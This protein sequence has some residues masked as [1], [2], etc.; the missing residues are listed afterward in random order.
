MYFNLLCT[1]HCAL[2][3][4]IHCEKGDIVPAFLESVDS[5]RG[6]LINTDGMVRLDGQSQA[7][8]GVNDFLSIITH[9]GSGGASLLGVGLH[10]VRGLALALGG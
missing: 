8:K 6:K 3:R 2:Y 10:G 1:R 7:R 5:S 9:K 4:N